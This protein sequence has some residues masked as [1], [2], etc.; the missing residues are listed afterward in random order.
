MG[1]GRPVAAR[2]LFASGQQKDAGIDVIAWRDF[3]DGRPSKP[4]MLAQAASGRN[5]KDKSVKNDIAPFMM[6]W[7]TRQPAQHILPAMLIPFP[8]HHEFESKADA[9]FDEVAAECIWRLEMHFGLILDR[10]RI[11]ETAAERLAE[12]KALPRLREWTGKALEAAQ[13]D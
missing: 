12:S 8:M 2:P 7:F 5:W 9:S 10:F 13:A 4:L 3:R 1:I 6:A 11:V